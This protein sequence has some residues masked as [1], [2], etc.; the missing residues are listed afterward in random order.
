MPVD[1]LRDVSVQGQQHV[2]LRSHL[3]PFLESVENEPVLDLLVGPLSQRPHRSLHQCVSLHYLCRLSKDSRS[4]QSVQ[5]V[6]PGAEEFPQLN[7]SRAFL[8][9]LEHLGQSAVLSQPAK[10]PSPRVV[11]IEGPLDLP[12]VLFDLSILRVAITKT[13]LLH[14]FEHEFAKVL[15]GKLPG[16]E[17]LDGLQK[18]FPPRHEAPAHS[19]LANGSGVP[20]G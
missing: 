20:P 12:Q 19:K 1:N 11:L 9:H 3:R 17:Q 2:D 15:V 16:L 6:R 10:R 8:P 5:H 18:L 7:G 13:G 14:A 4:A